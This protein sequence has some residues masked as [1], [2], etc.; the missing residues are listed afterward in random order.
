MNQSFL[1]QIRTPGAVPPEELQKVEQTYADILTQTGSDAA[2]GR[3]PRTYAEALLAV[4]VSRGVMAAVTSNF[5]S[6]LRDLYPNIP[7]LEEY[8]NSPLESKKSKDAFLVKL[9]DGQ[10]E[11]L[12]LDFLRVLNEKDRL[13]ML[14]LI[15]VA[16]RTLLEHQFGR[17]RVLVE[18]AAPLT[19]AQKQHLQDSLNTIMKRT[20]ILVVREN[21]ELIGGMV[22]RTGDRVFDT[23]VRTKLQTYRNQLLARGTHEIQSGRDRFRHI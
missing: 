23:S 2:M 17:Q 9:L 16:Y 5:V 4:A 18:V 19:D 3:I 20:P 6:L 8:L 21:P 7:Q 10:A 13:G 12:F 15:W 1:E 11:P 22:I 14:R